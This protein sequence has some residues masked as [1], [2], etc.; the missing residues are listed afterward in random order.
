MATPVQ[1]LHIDQLPP[2]LSATLLRAT[3]RIKRILLLRGLLAVA[4]TALI[5]LL[6]IIA[7]DASFVLYSQLIR[8]GLSLL[9]LSAVAWVAAR[10]LVR[11]LLQPYSPAKIATL[12]EQR[13]PELEE[14]L[15]TVVELLSMTETRERGSAQLVALITEAAEADARTVSPK[16][17]FTGRTIKPK[18]LVAGLATGI[19]ILLFAVWPDQFS[20]L[21]LRAL[22]PFAE[23]DN[24]F[25]SHLKVTPGSITLLVGEPLE[26]DATIT[27]ALQ[28]QAYLR[29]KPVNGFWSRETPERMRL[30][31]AEDV[32]PINERHFRQLFPAVEASFQYRIACGYALTRFYTVTAVERPTATILKMAY[33]YPDYIGKPARVMTNEFGEIAAVIGTKITIDTHINRPADV[34][35]TFIMIPRLFLH[36]RSTCK[37]SSSSA[38]RQVRSG[39]SY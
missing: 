2:E 10:H 23:L 5:A 28:G 17:E 30:I 11:P 26:V 16:R 29:K 21:C 35:G 31:P 19:V 22:A 13:H 7:I 34:T 38:K 9:G 24:L 15:S 20:L 27:R 6:A 1:A 14:R 8:F 18:L 25:G 4:A 39:E 36:S 33:T 3:R 12:I 37:N 32:T